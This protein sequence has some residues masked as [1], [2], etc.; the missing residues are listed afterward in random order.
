MALSIQDPR[1]F[2]AEHGH[3]QDPWHF[4]LNQLCSTLLLSRPR[5]GCILAVLQSWEGPV[6]GEL[7]ALA[8]SPRGLSTVL[9]FGWSAGLLSLL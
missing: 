8:E 2:T 9:A 3:S 5:G 6:Q 1:D 7:A 4:A